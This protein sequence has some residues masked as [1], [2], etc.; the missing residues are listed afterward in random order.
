VLVWSAASRIGSAGEYVDCAASKGAV[1]S[2]D[3][4]LSREVGGKGIRVNVV[5]R[6]TTLTDLHSGTGSSTESARW[7]R[8]PARAGS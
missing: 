1:D 7:S 4:G 2:L 8:N 6:G 3:I 5:R